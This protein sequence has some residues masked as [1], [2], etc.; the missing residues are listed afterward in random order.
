MSTKTVFYTSYVRTNLQ[1]I[2]FQQ[3]LEL[4]SWSCYLKPYKFTIAI[5]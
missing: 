5:C 1:I 2:E 4:M 3:Q